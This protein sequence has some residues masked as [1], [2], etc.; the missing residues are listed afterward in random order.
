[1]NQRDEVTKRY[2]DESTVNV[3]DRTGG[4]FLAWFEGDVQRVAR[5]SGAP[6][7]ATV[8]VDFYEKGGFVLTVT[9]PILAEPMVR[10]IAQTPTEQFPCLFIGNKAFV[11]RAEFR[12]M[13]LGSRSV[14]IELE[15]AR[16]IGEFAYVQVEAIGD[17]TTL[18]PDDTERQYSGYA[19]WPQLGF[20]G[21]IP[22]S[23]KLRSPEL[24]QFEKVSDVLAH[25]DGRTLWLK[26]GGDV[27]LRF[28]LRQGSRSWLVLDA[29]MSHNGIKVTR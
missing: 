1:M 22:Q 9:G 21:V 13:K 27:S 26:H 18:N 2:F 5:L 24:A 3:I 23:L 19:V 14:A 4:E 20:D 17:A 12:R 7:G 10:L 16:A 28:D 6:S 8:E 11:L 15:E 29:Y 25:P